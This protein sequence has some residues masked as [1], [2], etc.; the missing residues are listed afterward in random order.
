MH[1]PE[2]T[3]RARQTVGLVHRVDTVNREVTVLVGDELLT[4]DVPVAC[5]VLLHG[6]R[7]RFRMLQPRDLVRVRHTGR[8]S[9]RVALAIE[10][11]ANAPQ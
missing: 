1:R 6:E 10:A 4:F 5:E 3:V 9:L 2:P 7:V 11:Q 8:G